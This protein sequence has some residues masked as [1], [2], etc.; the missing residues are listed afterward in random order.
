MGRLRFSTMAVAVAG[1]TT[2]AP[3]A[4]TPSS[5]PTPA[6][7]ASVA[8]SERTPTG[9]TPT[10]RQSSPAATAS[11]ST[12]EPAPSDSGPATPTVT[13]HPIDGEPLGLALAGGDVWAGLVDQEAIVRFDPASAETTRIPSLGRNCVSMSAGAGFVWAASC[14]AG[15]L[16]QVDQRTH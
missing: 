10:P 5:K 14:E 8:T 11:A 1:C 16:V 7:T 4:S 2:A 6:A 3:G 15:P 12:I 9:R 13:T